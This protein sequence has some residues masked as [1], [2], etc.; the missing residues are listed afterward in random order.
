MNLKI[1]KISK[2]KRIKEGNELDYWFKL[3]NRKTHKIIDKIDILN[4]F[5]ES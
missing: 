3:S 5:Y 4:I 2:R 1:F